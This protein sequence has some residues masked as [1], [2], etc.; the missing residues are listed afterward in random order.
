MVRGGPG[1]VASAARGTDR[2][3]TA[4]V[5]SSPIGARATRLKPNFTGVLSCCAVRIDTVQH[6]A[7]LQS[8]AAALESDGA[9][10]DALIDVIASF[11]MPLIG[12]SLVGRQQSM[13]ELPSAQTFCTQVMVAK[14]GF[15]ASSTASARATDWRILFMTV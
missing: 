6:G 1:G 7:E 8:D 12:A 10:P 2:T 13:V 14:A 15:A 4:A 5:W 9:C 3:G 11:D